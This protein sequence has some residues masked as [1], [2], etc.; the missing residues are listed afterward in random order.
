MITVA[1]TGAEL[2]QSGVPPM[3]ET[4]EEFVTTAKECREAGA[5]MLV[6]RTATLAGLAQRPPMTRDQARAMVGVPDRH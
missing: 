3:A 1:P 5:A 4:L 2:D 6:E